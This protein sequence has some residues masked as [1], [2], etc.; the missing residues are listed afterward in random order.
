MQEGNQSIPIIV[1]DRLEENRVR[2]HF[3]FQLLYNIAD[4]ATKLMYLY[5]CFERIFE[6]GL[7]NRMH[8]LKLPDFIRETIDLGYLWGEMISKIPII[9]HEYE[10]I[11]VLWE[12]NEQDDA[13]RS[14]YTIYDDEYAEPWENDEYYEEFWGTNIHDE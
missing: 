7:V 4:N 10:G 1:I 11:S 12:Y 13:Y 8:L 9:T 6:E 5:A 2:H 14:T 3:D